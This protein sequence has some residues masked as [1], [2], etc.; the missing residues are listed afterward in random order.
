MFRALSALFISVAFAASAAAQGQ[1]IN[2]T[3]E[4]TVTDE[5]GAVLPG[6]TITLTNID[7]GETRVV[8]TNESGLYRAPLLQLGTYRVSAELAGFKKF[9]QTGI[10]LAAGQVA[11][12][13]I[14]LSVGAVTETVAVTAEAPVVDLG[15]IEQGRTLNERELKNLPNTSGNPYN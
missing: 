3:I 7:T 13:A 14:K 5:S 8:I 2:G 11:V 9:E 6:V 1:A 10:G 15:K 4:G 12:I